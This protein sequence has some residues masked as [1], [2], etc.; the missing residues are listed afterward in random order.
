M[1]FSMSGSYISEL[2][3]KYGNQPFISSNSSTMFLYFLAYLMNFALTYLENIDLQKYNHKPNQNSVYKEYD[4]GP[5]WTLLFP[6]F[7]TS[8]KWQTI[9]GKPIYT[10]LFFLIL[11]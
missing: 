7:K 9:H 10:L 1:N 6:N 2:V 5:C 3:R 11:V 4:V 8:Q